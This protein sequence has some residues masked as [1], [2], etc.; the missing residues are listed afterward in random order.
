[1]LGGRWRGMTHNP[2]FDAQLGAAIEPLLLCAGAGLLDCQRLEYGLGLLLLYLGRQGV[3][4]I[5]PDDMRLVLDGEKKLTAGQLARLLD[6]HA[7]VEAEAAKVLADGL[8]A[9]NAL[10]HG[11]LL[12]NFHRI[13]DPASREEVLSEVRALRRRVQAGEHVIRPRVEALTQEL[14]GL[15]TEQMLELAEQVFSGKVRDPWRR[16]TSG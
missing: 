6:R 5:S 4:D 11:Y 12:R 1:M 9:R 2:D 13:V 14:D 7:P 8:N 15:S 10:V 16:P 3:A